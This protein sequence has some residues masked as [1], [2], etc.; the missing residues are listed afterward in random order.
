MKIQDLVL[1]I[2]GEHPHFNNDQIAEEIQRRVPGSNTSAASVASMKSKAKKDGT[3]PQSNGFM[4]SH[5][6]STAVGYVPEPQMPAE[7]DAER[8]TRIRKRYSTLDRMAHQVALGNL[9]S[10]IV[11][12]PPGLGKSF[13]VEK[14]LKEVRGEATSEIVDEEDFKPFDIISGTISAVG[15]YIA[16]W[17]QR[18]N[19]VVVL[20][21]C[22]AVFNDETSLNLLKAVLDS[23]PDRWVSYRKRAQWM[24]EM[25]IPT[26]FPFNGSVVFCTNIDFESAIAKGSGL[27]PHFAALIDRSL[28]LSLTMRTHEDFMT[29]IY[30][31]AIEDG[32]LQRSGLSE[33]EAIEVMAF[34]EENASRFYSLSLRLVHQIAICFKASPETWK[35]DIEATKM[36]V[37]R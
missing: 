37:Y 26:S 3:L 11:S 18:D 10:L 9:P 33:E 35:D 32:M 28:Y 36:R 15:L 30:H 34:I 8:S 6:G 19:G 29:R 22:D 17:N 2:I 31:V 1:L 13:T 21:D 25:N 23:S 12:G 27:A 20:D 7:T 16:L 4:P 5:R 24:D 14:V